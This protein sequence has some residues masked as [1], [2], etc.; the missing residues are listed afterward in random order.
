MRGIAAAVDLQSKMTP[1]NGSSIARE[2]Q[3]EASPMVRWRPSCVPAYRLDSVGES[4]ESFRQ[5]L[6]DASRISDLNSVRFKVT[7]G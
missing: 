3:S 5:C 1:G 4:I 6:F 2:A 7:K